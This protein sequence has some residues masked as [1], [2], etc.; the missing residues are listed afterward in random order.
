MNVVQTLI[1]YVNNNAGIAQLVE[2]RIRNAKVSWFE[3]GCRLSLCP[4]SSVGR[5]PDRYSGDRWF[6]PGC[7]LLIIF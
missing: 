2:R 7:G 3:A 4:Y 1:S 5:A 6:D